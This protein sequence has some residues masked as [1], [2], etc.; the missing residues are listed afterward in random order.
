MHI[1]PIRSHRSLV[2]LF[3]V[4]A[5]F[6]PLATAAGA[7][8]GDVELLRLVARGQRANLG[9]I[10]TWQGEAVLVNAWYEGDSNNPSMQIKRSATFVCDLESPANRSAVTVL[11][12]PSARSFTAP[13]GHDAAKYRRE[14]HYTTSSMVKNQTL[15]Q[16][17][18]P[19]FAADMPHRLRITSTR[20][21]GGVQ[22][23][24]ERF[25]PKWYLTIRGRDVHELLMSYY[26]NA[27]HPDLTASV[28]RKGDI[29]TLE[30]PLKGSVTRYE[31]DLSQGCNLVS[32]AQ[33]LPQRHREDWTFRYEQVSGVFVPRDVQVDSISFPDGDTETRRHSSRRVSFLKNT[34]NEPIPTS[35]FELERLGLKEG[36]IV[37]DERIGVDYRYGH[38]EG[39]LSDSDLPRTSSALAVSDSDASATTTIATQANSQRTTAGPQEPVGPEQRTDR[40]PRSER[41]VWFFRGAT[42][43][44][45]GLA[46]L[47]SVFVWR[48]HAR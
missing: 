44:I 18:I 2:W 34:V 9:R 12:A 5:T 6:S 13:P 7:I 46:V 27:D 45:I 21:A 38:P 41:S 36:D 3:A 14:S 40:K 24:P 23:T 33:N 11:E 15:Y 4:V 43:A 28:R 17:R 10:C 26:S 25:D 48:R 22:N 30:C 8:Q 1:A 19:R 31:F 42:L 39:K 20:E 29:I 37:T 47:V 35:Q 16:L 32:F